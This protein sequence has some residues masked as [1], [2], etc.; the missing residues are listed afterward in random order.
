MSVCTVPPTGRGLLT[1]VL[2]LHQ[3][4]TNADPWCRPL[5]S[6]GAEAAG[7]L[8]VAADPVRE[9]PP[10]ENPEAPKEQLLPG[11]SQAPV[12]H[13][14][15]HSGKQGGSVRAQARVDPDPHRR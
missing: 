3:H 13:G 12:P 4:Q 1:A 11:I 2:S 10:V 6:S 8:A 14:R 15:G 9:S 7:T 5:E